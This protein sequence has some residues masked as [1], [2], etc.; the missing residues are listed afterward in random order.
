MRERAAAGVSAAQLS[1]E[2]GTHGSVIGRILS[3]TTY[4]DV[5][6]P[7][8]SP[9]ACPALPA[10]KVVAIREQA[11][12]GARPAEIAR[13]FGISRFQAIRIT[14]GKSRRDVGGP[15]VEPGQAP[16]TVARQTLLQ[17]ALAA[18]ASGGRF[19]VADIAR[20]MNVT[21]RAASTRVR[22]LEDRGLVEPCANDPGA[23]RVSAKGAEEIRR[24]VAE[25]ER[26]KESA[27]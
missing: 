16:G 12:A 8:R 11:A 4:S 17:C 19:R 9:S 14:R 3:G 5:P 2:H 20:R 27:E 23:R 18:I 15:I 13:A 22:R 25:S 24:I 26:E 10:S 21:S 7:T 1:R 6:G